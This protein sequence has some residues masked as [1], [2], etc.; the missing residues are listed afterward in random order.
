[1]WTHRIKRWLKCRLGIHQIHPTECKCLVC[2]TE[3]HEYEEVGEPYVKLGKS[4]PI[5]GTKVIEKYVFSCKRCGKL[6]C[7]DK[8]HEFHLADDAECKC[9]ICRCD[10]HEY[11]R[12]GEPIETIHGGT[13]KASPHTFYYMHYKYKGR[14]QRCGAE[15]VLD[16]YEEE[17]V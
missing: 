14:C 11:E 15:T 10:V 1:M 5:L 6:R 8:W 16:R 4:D 9:P 12:E 17:A 7:W 2:E 3:A 13:V